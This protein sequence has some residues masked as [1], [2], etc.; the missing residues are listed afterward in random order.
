[1]SEFDKFQ[2]TKLANSHLFNSEL[3]C[4]II[5]FAKQN[6]LILPDNFSRHDFNFYSRQTPHAFIEYS[7][8][9]KARL[10]T[11]DDLF[12]EQI[13]YLIKRL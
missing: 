1:M 9:F 5:E 10:K 7:I 6:D 8:V 2:F 12:R 4:F 3:E 11:S 13:E